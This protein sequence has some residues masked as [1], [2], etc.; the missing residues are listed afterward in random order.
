[1]SGQIYIYQQVGR[2]SVCEL[3]GCEKCALNSKCAFYSHNQPREFRLRVIVIGGNRVCGFSGGTFLVCLSFLDAIYAHISLFGDGFYIWSACSFVL[4]FVAM[5]EIG[6]GGSCGTWR[7]ALA[8]WLSAQVE[9]CN[10]R[11]RRFSAIGFEWR[12]KMHLSNGSGKKPNT[13]TLSGLPS[14][15]NYQQF[16]WIVI[17]D[18]Q[19]DQKQIIRDEHQSTYA[20]NI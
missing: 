7:N 5:Y 3:I 16:I 9:C 17:Y 8:N 19:T 6:S 12:R 15:E 1:M 10:R 4:R 20:K 2:F 11:R 18:M 13:H 14:N